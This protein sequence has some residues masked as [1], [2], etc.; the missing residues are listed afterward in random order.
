MPK[1]RLFVNGAIYTGWKEV[2]VTRSIEQAASTFS[3]SLSAKFSGKVSLLPIMPGSSCRLMF[4]DELV[5]TGYAD[6]I[7]GK[8]DDKSHTYTIAGRSKVGDLVDCTAIHKGGEFKNLKI[9]QIAAAIC[10]PFGISVRLDANEGAALAKHRTEDGT[11]HEVIERACRRR[12]LLLT[13]D[14]SGDLVITEVGKHRISTPL[15]QGENIKGGSGEFSQHKRHSEYIVKG[16][17]A[18]NDAFDPERTTQ[19]AG[20]AN[21]PAVRRYRPLVLSAE[22]GDE[23]LSDRAAFEAT[24]RLGRSTQLAYTVTSWRHREG[25]WKPN[26]LVEVKDPYFGVHGWFLLMSV[27]FKY[28]STNGTQ[29]ELKLMPKEAFSIEKLKE[30]SSAKGNDWGDV[31]GDAAIEAGDSPKGSQSRR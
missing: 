22:D 3:I 29:A 12:G 13:S 9:S 7:S 20:K 2:T 17:T 10:E 4:D 28:S 11:C 8:Y 25:L 6:K 14:P 26:S 21:D 24:T 15:I 19:I 5:I 23:S 1:V 27:T 30:T 31:F 16:Q 18:G